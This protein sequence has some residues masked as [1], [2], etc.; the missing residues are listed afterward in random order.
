MRVTQGDVLVVALD[1]GEV[2]AGDPADGRRGVVAGAPQPLGHRR[3][4][5]P[6]RHP[7][8]AADPDVDG[9]DGPPA[10]RGQQL[11]AHLLQRQPPLD[12][13]AVVL[14][15]LDRAVV[16]EEVGGVQQVDVQ[17]V[18]GDPLAA[19]QQPAQVGQGSLHLDPP[20][21]LDRLAGAHL[22]GDRADAADPGGDV[23]RLRGLPTSQQRLEEA[24]RL[25]DA[26][27]GA[28]HAPAAGPHHQRPLALHPGERAHAHHAAGVVGV[29]H[30]RSAPAAACPAFRKGS[31]AALKVRNTRATS[32]PV[33][34]R[35]ARRPLSAAVFGVSAGPKQP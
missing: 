6:G 34:P 27:L 2:E 32:S 18:T 25:V 14:G 24:G 19:V 11:V 29:A 8:E 5:A 23:G 35:P 26:Q 17:G 3:Q 12:H 21:V 9:V 15:Q 20:G 28:E 16:A 13:R 31:A 1:V 33:M 22:V 7:V 10:D 30:D 4:L